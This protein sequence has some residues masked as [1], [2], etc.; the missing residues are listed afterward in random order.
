M[1]PLMLGCF[2]YISEY[3][4]DSHVMFM[5]LEPNIMANV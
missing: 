2:E 1:P 4:L 3:V 5:D